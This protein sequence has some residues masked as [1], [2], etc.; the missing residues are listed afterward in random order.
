MSDLTSPVKSNSCGYALVFKAPATVEE[1]DRLAGRAGTCL[2]DAIDNTIYR[3]TLVEWQDAMGDAIVKLTGVSR[4]V[5]TDATNKAKSRSKKPESVKDI[6]ERFKAFN[7][8]V[9]ASWATMTNEKDETLED[10][11]KLGQLK[12]LAQTVADTIT[13]DPSP[14]K[15]TGGISKE[16]TAKAD[17]I[18]AQTET[19]EAKVA[20]LLGLVPNFVL[21]RDETGLPERD[22][23][24][25]LV[26]AYLDALSA[27]L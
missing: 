10:P 26:G 9:I 6:P 25:R 12:A 5:D 24:A 19:V 2:E 7:S 23:L 11:E 18:L 1:Y 17:S 27:D 20:K 13:V 3:G 8:R 16:L 22:S 14:S 15:R 21:V 4:G